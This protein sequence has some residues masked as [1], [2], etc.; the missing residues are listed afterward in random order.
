M[1]TIILY[2]QALLFEPFSTMTVRQG[3]QKRQSWPFA[4]SLIKEFV[5]GR[6][7]KASKCKNSS[8]LRHRR[9]LRIHAQFRTFY[10]ASV[11]DHGGSMAWDFPNDLIC[12]SHCIALAG[13]DGS[14]WW[15]LS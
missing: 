12:L 10:A 14:A 13:S 6:R 15:Y 7:R 1:R 2:R 11:D 3:P 9:P 4:Y 8:F 5:V